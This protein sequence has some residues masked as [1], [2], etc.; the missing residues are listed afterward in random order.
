MF[1]LVYLAIRVLARLIVTG[2]HGGRDD[3]AKALEIL[4]LRHQ[5]RVLRRTSGPPRYRAIDR[6]LLAAASRS[7]PRDRWV[8]FLVTPATLLRWH[9]ELVR[10]KW[11]YRRTGRP[12][13]PPIDAEVRQLI[14]RLARENPRW[15]CVRIQGELRKLGIRVGTTTIRSLLRAARTGPAPRRAGPTWTEFLRA[16]GGGI[17]ACDFF[18]V[19]TAWVRTL[20]ALVFIELGSRRIFV[21]PSTAHPDSAWVTQQARNLAMELD[22]RSTAIR[23]LIRDRDTKFTRAF[24][25]VVRSAGARVILTPVRAPNAN[26]YAER[27]IETIRAECLDW[28]LI[29]GRRHLDRTLRTYAEHYN[30]GRPHRGL[31]LAPPVAEAADPVP[32]S[33]RDVRRRDLL[34]GLIHEYHGRAA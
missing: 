5:L 9:R 6:V 23:F 1:S 14:L 19:E 32:V 2:G 4:V 18:T 8:A 11:T 10:K 26:A 31:A 21:S 24:D 25:E 16:Q 7:I 28:S 3:G 12:G 13:R 34:G 17:V 30:R 29:L 15:G 20:Y 27:V 33:P 22:D